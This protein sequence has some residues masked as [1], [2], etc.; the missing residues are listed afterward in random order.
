MIRPAKDQSR[1]W[2]FTKPLRKFFDFI[3]RHKT[4][5][6]F[7]KCL[8]F[9]KQNGI[10][11]TIK[12]VN[13]YNKKEKSHKPLASLDL[14]TLLAKD[15]RLSQKNTIFPKQIKISIV[16]PLYN[17]PK[18][19]L[20][21]MIQSVKNQTYGNWELCLADGSDNEHKNVKLICKSFARY[22]KRIKYKKLNNNFGISGNSN[23]AMEMA[24]GEYIGL[25]DHDDVLHPSALF[26]VMKA[27][28]NEDADFIYSDEATFTNDN[29]EITVK[30]YK[31][32]YAIDTL[33]S[34]NYICHFSVFSRKLTEQAGTFRSEFDGSQDY[35]LI[36]RYT[37][38]ASKICHIPQL[39]Y[40]WRSHG[41][42][43]AADIG[44]KSYAITA[45][46]N[47]IMEHLT[48][49]GISAQIESTK[50]NSSFYKIIYDLTERPL[51][52]I[53]I[54]NKD[55]VPILQKCLSSIKEKTTYGDYEIII[56]ENNSEEK[57][58]FAYYEELKNQ[59]NIHIVYWEEKGFNYSKIN[60]YGV[61]YAHGKHLIFL[62]NDVEIITPNWIEEMLMFSQ[63]SDV[64]AV[65][66]K[67]YF[68]DDTIQH[69]G[70]IMGMGGIAGHIY[71]GVP[72]DTMG[73]MG[74]LHIVQNMSAVTAACM[75]IRKSVFNEVGNF[76]SE[77]ETSFNDVDLCLKIRNAGYLIVWTPFAEAYHYESKTRGYPDTPDKQREFVI[78]IDKFKAKWGKELAAGDPYYNCNY[79]LDRADY[80]EK[81]KN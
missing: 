55:H 38:I 6:L 69:A 1:Y 28:C 51:V 59:T 20:K 5:C 40:F 26:E 34:C 80:F 25:L 64:G 75:M 16:T 52:S 42:S 78:D 2:C 11:A 67:L 15:K 58:T 30:H 56:V 27:I 49:Q 45:A 33:R 7:A 61:Q 36:L 72:R 46:K 8:I 35:D 50:V 3:R 21:E 18:R 43:A 23:K 66:I 22:D 44:N 70:V 24:C 57:T 76:S 74:R 13:A 73:Y 37:D 29:N 71:P 79:S 12:K 60:N 63:R 14:Y 62:N 54:S 47:A 17:T 4:L 31:P 19:F 81:Q 77:L 39:L 9:I 41:D 48:K 65:G 10:K 53:I 68:P 32:D